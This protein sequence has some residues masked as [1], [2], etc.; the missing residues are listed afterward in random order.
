MEGKGDAAGV[1]DDDLALAPLVELLGL[2]VERDLVEAVVDGA[3]LAREGHRVVWA[4]L[5]LAH[6]NRGELAAGDTIEDH[7]DLLR[8]AGRDDAAER[9]NVKNIVDG[10][11][12]AGR[13]G[14]AA[15]RGVGGV[16][17]S[18]SDAADRRVRAASSAARRVLL[19]HPRV[20]R[21]NG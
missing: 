2:K 4:A 18:C 20:A 19:K 17:R 13:R 9:H 7:L 6:G 21:R 11:E 3:R 10:D 14:G 5:N 16:N 1:G 12:G 8:D 15:S